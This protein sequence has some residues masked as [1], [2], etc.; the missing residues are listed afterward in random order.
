MKL[1]TLACLASA[2]AILAIAACGSD[3]N[4]PPTPGPGQ[5]ASFDSFVSSSGSSGT[6]GG[7]D[8]SSGN[9]GS[10]SG[11]IDSGQD[12]GVDAKEAGYTGP[13]HFLYA[14]GTLAAGSAVG[15]IGYTVDPTNG[16]LAP[17]DTDGVTA[18]FQASIAAGIGPFVGAAT[19]AG[20]NLYAAS[21]DGKTIYGFSVDPKTGALTPLAT[22]STGAAGGSPYFMR[23]DAAGK[24]LYVSKR[25]GSTIAL[26]DIGAGGAL[27]PSA[28]TPEFSTMT[29]P[30]GIALSTAGDLLFV[31]NELSESVS[32]FKVDA[33]TGV[34]SARKDSS[35]PGTPIAMAHHTSKNVLYVVASAAVTPDQAI[36]AFSYDATGA[37]T[38]VGTTKA[39]GR[40]PLG[41]A[42][43][44]TGTYLYVS[45][46][47]DPA[48]TSYPLDP[49]TGALGTA[50]TTSLQTAQTGGHGITVDPSGKYLLL[51][52]EANLVTVLSIGA[53]GAV[54]PLPNT[55]AGTLGSYSFY[56]PMIIAH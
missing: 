4:G 1:R 54:T 55:I 26:F 23:S 11:T 53:A 20:N 17:F 35:A 46:A 56:D 25:A 8:S 6:S 24:H 43:D 19:P 3:D 45:S 32:A 42:V 2:S 10:S 30:R 51:A 39:A 33:T 49:A 34:L 12:A 31:A 38:Q 18:G 50:V 52:G 28:T 27:T 21:T 44:L 22:T 16:D 15:V 29:G 41:A 37:L 40:T 13:A 14:M 7:V 5:D 9:D 36:T 47:G 48:I